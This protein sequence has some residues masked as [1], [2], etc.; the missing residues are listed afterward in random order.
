[1]QKCSRFSEAISSSS[2]TRKPK[3]PRETTLPT[4]HRPTVARPP[5]QQTTLTARRSRPR[6]PVTPPDPG[7][8]THA[9]RLRLA[10]SSPSL[11]SPL[12]LQ[13]RSRPSLL[14]NPKEHDE[15]IA[16][17]ATR[18]ARNPAAQGKK[19]VYVVRGSDASLS[20]AGL[21]SGIHPASGRGEG[22]RGEREDP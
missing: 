6:A 2:S 20:R 10:L 15:T 9:R 21:G 8:E 7:A 4:S 14:N 5:P 17:D 16:P 18:E 3:S 11:R 19:H 22:A 12:P 13:L 1:M